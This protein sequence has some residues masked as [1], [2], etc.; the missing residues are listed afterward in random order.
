MLA[1]DLGT[2]TGWAC[3]DADGEIHSGVWKLQPT[4][5]DSPGTRY[6]NLCRKLTEAHARFSFGQVYYEAIMFSGTT[7]ATQ[8]WGGLMAHLMTWC[9]ERGVEYT[10]VPVG[11]IKKFWTGKGNANKTAMMLECE[12]R[13]F[14]PIDDNHADALALLHMSMEG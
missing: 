6:S 5:F 11:K 12:R 1:L 2:T 10:G 4:R 9:D 7:I 14:V 8:V 13:G 3:L